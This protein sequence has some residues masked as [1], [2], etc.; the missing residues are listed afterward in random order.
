MS[1]IWCARQLVAVETVAANETKA[2]ESVAELLRQAGIPFQVV[3][4]APG[5]DNLIAR[6]KGNGTK[7]PLLLLAHIDVVPVAGRRNLREGP[8]PSYWRY[9]REPMSCPAYD[10]PPIERQS[11]PEEQGLSLVKR[12]GPTAATLSEWRNAFLA[13]AE[14]GLKSRKPSAADEENNRLREVLVFVLPPSHGW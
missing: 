14:A 7:R 13:S 1:E 2:L 5:R 6:I 10:K 9:W 3:E 8:W 4:S 11:A 12:A